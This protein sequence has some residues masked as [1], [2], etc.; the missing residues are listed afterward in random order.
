VP[1]LFTPLPTGRHKGLHYSKSFNPYVLVKESRGAFKN[2]L[3][4]LSIFVPS[5]KMANRFQVVLETT[6]SFF[7]A[8]C[9]PVSRADPYST[10]P[11]STSCPPSPPKNVIMLFVCT[12]NSC[13]NQPAYA[14]WIPL[15]ICFT[16]VF[17]ITHILS[18]I[19][20]ALYKLTFTSHTGT[21]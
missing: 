13:P 11:Y 12:K 20:P 18:R 2:D 4:Y 6:S 8:K 1:E 9:C 14:G 19:L 10:D 7:P 5:S 16:T 3:K 17:P 21:R 15:F